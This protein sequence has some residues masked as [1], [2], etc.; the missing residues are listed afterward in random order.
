MD[1]RSISIRF[2]DS[3]DAALIAAISRTTFYD[4]FAASNTASD[5]ELFLKEQFTTSSL[6]AEVSVKSNIFL[7]VYCNDSVAGYV[8]LR[9]VQKPRG[10]EAF[11]AMEIARIYV[12]REMLGQGI[13]KMLMQFV[14]DLCRQ[15]TYD[16]IWLSVW[17]KNQRA[18][19]FYTSWGF[20]IFDQQVFVLGKDLQND[21]LML[22][23][24]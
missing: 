20:T 8:K 17:E 13:G 14:V 1:H 15:R 2:A 21:W 16:V 19:D 22:K 24:L 12:I 9:D 4:T 18:F 3:K 6:I 11:S 10:L 5:M 7:L 23:M